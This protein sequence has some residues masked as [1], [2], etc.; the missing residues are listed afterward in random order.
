M[1]YFITS[2]VCAMVKVNGVFLNEI[3]ANLYSFE[4]NKDCYIEIIPLK[5]NL[6][7]ICFKVNNVPYKSKNL[8]LY[9]F[10]NGILILPIFSHKNNLPFKYVYSSNN[11]E[12]SLYV[13][14]DNC[15]KVLI[16]TQNASN[17][18]TLPFEPLK[19][20]SLFLN[21]L[22]FLKIYGE[23]K[24][25][26]IC[27]NLNDKIDKRF[28]KHNADIPLNSQSFKCKC[29]N[30]T[31]IEQELYFNNNGDITKQIN[32]RNRAISLLNPLLFP[33]A[34]LEE[35]LINGDYKDYFHQSLLQHSELVLNFLGEFYS[36]IPYNKD[37]DNLAILI[38]QNA[39]TVKFTL[40]D[41]KIIDLT[42]V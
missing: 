18:F 35:V 19:C 13:Y 27:F 29:K 24:N 6:N 11:N 41:N 20:E 12:N 1:I 10:E 4:C 2:P 42:I 25:T 37:S 23:N 39:K 32:T 16:Q 9:N 3:D 8:C 30:L 26:L 15:S 36:F 22:L 40:E 31:K 34:F 28:V 33:F 7:A 21:E 5:E 38:G 17:V 14:N